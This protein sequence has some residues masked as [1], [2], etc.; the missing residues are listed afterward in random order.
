[1]K[2]AG[3]GRLEDGWQRQG[4][5]SITDLGTRQVAFALSHPF[6]MEILG[7]LCSFKYSSDANN[8]SIIYN[9]FHLLIVLI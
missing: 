5:C 2:E 3:D 1:M 6:Q 7:F 8:P 9:D 4:S